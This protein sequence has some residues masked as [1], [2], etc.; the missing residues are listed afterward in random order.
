MTI[1]QHSHSLRKTFPRQFQLLKN[2]INYA[3]LTLSC[4]TSWTWKKWLPHTLPSTKLNQIC[5]IYLFELIENA[6]PFIYLKLFNVSWGAAHQFLPSFPTV[7][8]NSCPIC[9]K[10]TWLLPNFPS[11][12]S[13]RPQKFMSSLLFVDM[14]SIQL[15]LRLKC[16]QK[17]MSSTHQ[18]WVPFFFSL[19]SDIIVPI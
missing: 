1:H 18:I 10:L 9:Y 8:P 16:R 12:L 3:E 4:I 15:P 11:P 13:S 19:F 6:Q 17:L 7:H 5:R 2:K 14:T